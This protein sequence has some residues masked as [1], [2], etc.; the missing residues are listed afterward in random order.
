MRR[1]VHKIMSERPKRGCPQVVRGLYV[2]PK[3]RLLVRK[4]KLPAN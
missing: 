4:I 1:D 3:S 2:H